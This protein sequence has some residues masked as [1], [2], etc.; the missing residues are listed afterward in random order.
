VFGGFKTNDTILPAGS[1]RSNQLASALPTN[2]SFFPTPDRSNH[3][4]HDV[5]SHLQAD[6]ERLHQ[7]IE[8]SNQHMKDLKHQFE[9]LNRILQ[10]AVQA[11]HAP[12]QAAKAPE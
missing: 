5:I 9:E 6:N 11:S 2:Y 1:V 4:L 8:Q 12:A 7:Q 3:S 10:A